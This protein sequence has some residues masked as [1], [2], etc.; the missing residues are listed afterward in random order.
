[1]ITALSIAHAILSSTDTLIL[2]ST[3]HTSSNFRTEDPQLVHDEGLE[4]GHIPEKCWGSTKGAQG[5][6]AGLGTYPA[7][8]PAANNL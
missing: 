4:R 6:G 7:D 1:M 3:E 5:E 8:V 2:L